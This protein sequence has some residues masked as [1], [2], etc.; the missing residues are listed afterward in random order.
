MDV[1]GNSKNHRN[2][3]EFRRCLDHSVHGD[4]D[5]LWRDL[6]R[7]Q[8]G[9][10]VL[11]SSHRDVA[12]SLRHCDCVLLLS[13]TFRACGD[14]RAYWTESVAADQEEQKFHKPADN[15]LHETAN[16]GGVD[17]DHCHVAVLYLPDSIQD[18]QSVDCAQLCGKG[19]CLWAGELPQPVVVRQD[20]VLREF[21]YESHRV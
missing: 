10:G 12:D 8:Q 21:Q 6:L 14:L 4:G 16:T 13:V 17:V 18:R 7:R 5:P 15:S 1:R 3:L 9:Q 19:E 20:H 2:P 11:H